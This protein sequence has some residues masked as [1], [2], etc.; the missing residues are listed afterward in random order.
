[1]SRWTTKRWTVAVVVTLVAAL[2]TGIPTGIIST[3]FYTR[4]TPVLWWNYPVW[5]VTAVLA[6]LLA[7]TYRGGDGA[8]SSGVSGRVSVG[9]VMSA[10]AIGCPVCNKVVV[11]L[12]GVSGALGIWAPLQPLIGVASVALLGIAL[13][14]RLRT[15][16]V[17][18]LPASGRETPTGSTEANGPQ[19]FGEFAAKSETSASGDRLR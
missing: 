11:A 14:L 12:L 2:V 3:G 13:W 17:C 7:A 15:P 10:L 8:K 16:P 19:T 4:M 6:G 18:K 1:M 9:S 5:A